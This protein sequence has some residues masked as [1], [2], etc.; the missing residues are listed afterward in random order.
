MVTNLPFHYLLERLSGI[1]CTHQ[2]PNHS[3]GGASRN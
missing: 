3:S 2:N 1:I